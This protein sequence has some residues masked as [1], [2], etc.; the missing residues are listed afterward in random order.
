MT[1]VVY[2]TYFF[3]C[4]FTA[5]RRFNVISATDMV[6]RSNVVGTI[7]LFA[8]YAATSSG[9][10]ASA[11]AIFASR[12]GRSRS[13]LCPFGS[14]SRTGLRSR[15]QSQGKSNP[16]A[17]FRSSASLRRENLGACHL[18][19]TREGSIA[20]GSAPNAFC[21]ALRLL[22]IAPPRRRATRRAAREEPLRRPRGRARGDVQAE[23]GREGEAVPLRPAQPRVLQGR[24]HRALPHDPLLPHASPR[25]AEHGVAA[26]AGL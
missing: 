24:E 18:P 20:A 1:T 8:R 12:I 14:R 26:I 19:F 2:G 11:A 9:C 5:A 21:T 17:A 7:F 22:N 23:G 10:F 4:G 3:P 13:C 16:S 15:S 6:S 25:D